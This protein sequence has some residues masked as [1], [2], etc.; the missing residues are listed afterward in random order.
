MPDNHHSGLQQPGTFSLPSDDVRYK[1]S[2]LVVYNMQL[3]QANFQLLV[4]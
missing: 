3:T 4:I 2:D 1:T